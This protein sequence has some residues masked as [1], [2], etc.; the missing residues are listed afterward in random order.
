M[1][2]PSSEPPATMGTN[3]PTSPKTPAVATPRRPSAI[4]QDHLATP[5]LDRMDMMALRSRVRDLQ[6]ENAKQASLL[7]SSGIF[8]KSL[9]DQNDA[10]LVQNKQLMAEL[11]V[12]QKQ[13]AALRAAAHQ[14]GY[15][16]P[17]SFGMS[18]VDVNQDTG[19][20]EDAM[21]VDQDLATKRLTSELAE[22]R[23][24]LKAAES[25]L[26]QLRRE[27]EVLS[28]EHAATDRTPVRELTR[29][30]QEARDT[31]VDRDRELEHVKADLDRVQAERDQAVDAARHALHK[32]EA[33]QSMVAA[34]DGTK[35]REEY[36]Q[37]VA[38]LSQRLD[39]ESELRV[40]LENALVSA[41]EEKNEMQQ[42]MDLL[43][44]QLDELFPVRQE[45][46]E[47]MLR[48]D[49][50]ASK[51]EEARCQVRDL[52]SQVHV[53]RTGKS[54]N[55]KDDPSAR[56]TLLS[57]VD[58]DRKRAELHKARLAAE[59]E[60]TLRA[61]NKRMERMRQQVHSLTTQANDRTHRERVKHL[62]NE[63]AKLQS[64]NRELQ[65]RVDELETARAKARR[66]S[67][68]PGAAVAAAA[69]VGGFAADEDSSGSVG[70][71]RMR[72]E[73]L[74]RAVR[75]ARKKL[76]AEQMMRANETAKLRSVE[77]EV[78]QRDGSIS[79]LNS[80]VAKYRLR[81]S[82]LEAAC[83]C[84]KPAPRTSSGN[85]HH[86]AASSH[87]TPYQALTSEQPMDVP[88]PDAADTPASSPFS[89][90]A[91]KIKRAPTPHH[92]VRTD[93]P[94]T[95][96]PATTSR[97]GMSIDLT[98][99][100]G[101]PASSIASG[102]RTPGSWEPAPASSMPPPS[103]TPSVRSRGKVTILP[104]GGVQ[105]TMSLEEHGSAPHNGEDRPG[106]CTPQ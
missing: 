7:S 49:D 73:E 62:E 13:V 75:Q 71:L 58:D 81:I 72:V 33:T 69:A 80:L 27:Y 102:E 59:H 35:L 70:V 41:V 39:Q 10:L 37:V 29:Y 40:E 46:D 57:E 28:E 18:P 36:S 86:R 30:L 15:T 50:L 19:D 82:E 92:S 26:L 14:A 66:A 34:A 84:P 48:A 12:A 68:V 56:K 63:I 43:E 9:L 61:H 88:M 79:R 106:E 42:R 4:V 20:N 90:P 105:S 24:Q 93:P 38:D 77:D 32:L 1:L 31:I 21:Q 78:Y 8:G 96:S 85:A 54:A 17:P 83:E 89:K 101:S 99:V 5:H 95:P 3:G 104:R 11:S 52:E 103:G 94:Q 97:A 44:S 55:A 74:E 51:L 87:G 67:L 47:A 22:T 25:D 60:Q 100:S 2:G 91:F 76:Q 64:E 53:L 98:G 6:R 16:L 45:L 65:H 23:A